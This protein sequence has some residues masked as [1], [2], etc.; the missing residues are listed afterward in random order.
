MC[1]YMYVRRV[2]L[3]EHRLLLCLVLN[4]LG[5]IADI[6]VW[7][8]CLHKLVGFLYGGLILGVIH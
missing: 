1:I 4:S 3:I 6:S 2:S 5:P 8:R 7:Y